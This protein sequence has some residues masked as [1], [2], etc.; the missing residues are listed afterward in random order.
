EPAEL[1][2]GDVRQGGPKQ[3]R[4][5]RLGHPRRIGPHRAPLARLQGARHRVEH[6]AV[7]LD[8]PL[9][10]RFGREQQRLGVVAGDRGALHR[11]RPAS[12]C[13]RYCITSLRLVSLSSWASSSLD[14]AAIDRST[15]S[16]RSATIAFSF[17]APISR[18]AR[19]SSWSY[20]WRALASSV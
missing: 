14:A 10:S 8:R 18:R 5:G 13:A 4:L 2:G 6:P 16:R 1:G 12:S 19:S 3:R 11:A 20:S 9:G 17:S 15:A 7:Q